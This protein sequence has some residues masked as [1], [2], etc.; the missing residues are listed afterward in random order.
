MNYAIL[1]FL[2]STLYLVFRGIKAVLHLERESS[3]SIG[4]SRGYSEGVDDATHA[5]DYYN[6]RSVRKAL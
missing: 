5:A 6:Q 3:Y 1:V 4:F 2:A